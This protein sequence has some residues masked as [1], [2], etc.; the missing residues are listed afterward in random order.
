MN[1]SVHQATATHSEVL[2]LSRVCR[3]EEPDSAARIGHGL[4]KIMSVV[5]NSSASEGR[6]YMNYLAIGHAEEFQRCVNWVQCLGG[7]LMFSP[8]EKLTLFFTLSC[9]MVVHAV[10]RKGYSDGMIERKSLVTNFQY[11]AGATHIL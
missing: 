5:L 9:A 2:Q 7:D 10:I 3:H 8:D 1:L 4:M 6:R 11:L